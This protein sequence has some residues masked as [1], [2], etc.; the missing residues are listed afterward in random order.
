MPCVGPTLGAAIALASL[1]EQL[2]HAFVIMWVY[3][4]GAGLALSVIAS[5]STSMFSSLKSNAKLLRIIMGLSLFAVGL[6]VLTGFD[7]YLET[8]ALHYLPS[9]IYSL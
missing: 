4:L 6:M 9:W 5:L 8:L 7:K 3:G 1:G 2:D